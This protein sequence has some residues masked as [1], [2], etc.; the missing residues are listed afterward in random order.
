MYTNVMQ[1]HPVYFITMSVFKRY[2]NKKTLLVLVFSFSGVSQG[3]VT[4]KHI[5][6]VT[7]L[8]GQNNT[9]N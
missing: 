4:W 1:Q 5:A 3:N 7:D 8:D 6:K 2:F 9:E